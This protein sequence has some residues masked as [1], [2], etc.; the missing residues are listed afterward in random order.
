MRGL[1]R[2]IVAVV[3]ASVLVV[4]QAVADPT[5]LLALV[6]WPGGGLQAGLVWPI[7]PYA[8]FVPVLLGVVWWAAVR[9]GERFWT[10]FA[11]VVLAVLLAQAAAAFVMVW[12]AA[13]AAWAAGYVAAKALPA[14]AVVAAATRWLGGR[15]ARTTSEPGSVWPAAIAFGALAPIAAAGSWWTGAAYAPLVPTPRP[16]RGFVGVAVAVA[17]MIG[18]AWLCLRWM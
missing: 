13:T 1:R 4:L 12:D 9:A 3:A 7:A 8:V 2:P 16:E 14:A 10:M 5:G 17:L 6:G 11:G 18:A 15:S